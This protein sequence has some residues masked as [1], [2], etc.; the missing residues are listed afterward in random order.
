[1]SHTIKVLIYCLLMM[2]EI[3]AL[4]NLYIKSYMFITF[5][6][7]TS[8]NAPLQNLIVIGQTHGLEEA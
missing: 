5:T 8:K 4:F 2:L 1:M 6:M 3:N 7:K